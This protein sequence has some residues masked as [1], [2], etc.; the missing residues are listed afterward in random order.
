MGREI[1]YMKLSVKMLM[2]YVKLILQ[3]LKELSI[4]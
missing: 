1:Q 3:F 4:Y 2:G